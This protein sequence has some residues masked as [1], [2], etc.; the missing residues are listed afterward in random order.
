[1]MAAVKGESVDDGTGLFE[2]AYPPRTEI[3]SVK[4]LSTPPRKEIW[5]FHRTGTRSK[6]E[7]EFN[8][9]LTA[10]FVPLVRDT[11][12]L[13]NALLQLTELDWSPRIQRP[14]SRKL[15]PARTD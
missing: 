7:V 13:L 5:S 9:P 1:M 12:K 14:S 2:W 4:P 11:G 8:S 10:G 3:F 6:S 15:T